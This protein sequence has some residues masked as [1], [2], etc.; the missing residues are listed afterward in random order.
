MHDLFFAINKQRG[1]TIVVVTHNASLAASMPRVVTLRDGRV[2]ETKTKRRSGRASEEATTPRA[3]SFPATPRRAL[4]QRTM[5]G[6]GVNGRRTGRSRAATGSASDAVVG[7]H[8]IWTRGTIC[9]GRSAR[10]TSGGQAETHVDLARLGLGPCAP[11]QRDGHPD[12]W[13]LRH[14]ARDLDGGRD[15]GHIECEAPRRAFD[16]R[17]G[18]CTCRR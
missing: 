13:A 10:T 15:T 2:V 5:S 1:T 16:R 3:D 17:A 18:A 8:E 7:R 4:Y 14:F 6:A 9:S 11:H 12:E